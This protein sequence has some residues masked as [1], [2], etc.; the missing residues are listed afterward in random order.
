ME[1]A[2]TRETIRTEF[3]SAIRL[4]FVLVKM[5]M[6]NLRVFLL[7]YAYLLQLMTSQAYVQ[8]TGILLKVYIVPSLLVL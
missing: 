6:N 7:F 4:R 1:Y 3:V 8:V 5:K 2:L